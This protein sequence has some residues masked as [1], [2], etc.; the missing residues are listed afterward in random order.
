M[1]MNM[2]VQALLLLLTMAGPAA[3]ENW[4]QWRGPERTGVSHETGL[5][6]KWSETENITWKL[7]LPTWSGATPIVWRERIF[8]NVAEDEDKL[9]FWCVD[10]TK[11]EVL[12]KRSMGGGNRKARKQNM[13]S[14]SPATDGKNIWVMTGTGILKSFDFQGNEKWTRDIQ[15][16]YG[17][18]GLNHGY[19]NS[20]LLH[21]GSLYVQV[22][23]GMHTDDPSYILRLD[24]NTGKTVWRVERP[25]P[26][27][28]ESPD[29]YTT[30][31]L[32]NVGGKL[33]LVITGGDVIT[34]HDLA[35][36]KELW[37]GDGFNVNNDPAYRIVASPVAVGELVLAP[38]RIKPMI[39]FRGG[40]RGNVSTSHRVWSTQ[41]GPDVPTPVTDG[42]LLWVV[43]DKGIYWC[44]DWKT[45]KEVWGPQRIRTGTYSTSPVLA[46]GKI[47]VTSEDGVTTV[48]KASGKFEVLAENTIDDY[49][50]SSIA[51]SDGQIFLRTA[52]AL[53]CIGQRKQ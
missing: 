5:A 3:A 26:A 49:V 6:L 22:T 23:H 42:K 16:E 34:G 18:F 15:K 40:G 51:V 52:K 44:F 46:D 30:P 43:N 36:G 33:E 17:K 14:P 13:S 41:N 39:M 12:W 10:R 20:P 38:T 8:L 53:Y 21:E 50:L 11:G 9:A 37:R 2:Q 24:K 35:T 25:T 28:R 4:P 1:K 19:A 27:I 48:I 7:P 29:S 31:T 47:Y 32:V 45:G